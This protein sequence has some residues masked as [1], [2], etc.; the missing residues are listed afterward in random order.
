MTG[1]RKI[2]IEVALPLK[3][4]NHPYAMRFHHGCRNSGREPDFAATSVNYDWQE[5]KDSTLGNADASAPIG[6]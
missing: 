5:R 3:A 1:E 6:M 4:S 2:L